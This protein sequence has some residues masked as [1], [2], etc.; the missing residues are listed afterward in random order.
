MNFNYYFY[1]FFAIATIW[2]CN[3]TG[4]INDGVKN[5]NIQVDQDNV[6]D[7]QIVVEKVIP[8]ETT[9]ESIFGEV[10]KVIFKNDGFF[11]HDHIFTNNIYQFDEEGQYTSKLDI[12]K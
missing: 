12:G 1:L 6:G 7:F 8:L 11:V 2:S 9:D 5:T 10:Y 3:S 4:S